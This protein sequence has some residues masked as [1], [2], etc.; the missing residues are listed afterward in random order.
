MWK[1]KGENRKVGAF[2]LKI[3]NFM[4]RNISRNFIGMCLV[5][6]VCNQYNVREK[7][8]LSDT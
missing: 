4:V 2:K 8:K 6:L 3:P 5:V 7:M 1:K